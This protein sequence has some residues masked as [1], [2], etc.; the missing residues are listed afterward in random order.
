MK[1]AIMQPYFFPYAGYF[2]LIDQVDKFVFYDDVGF[3]K[4][5]W[6]NRNRLLMAGEAR[7]FTVPLCGASPNL[8]INQVK[9]QP[10]EMWERKLLASIQQSY[11]KAPN[12]AMAFDCLREVLGAGEYEGIA[13]LAKRSIRL[14]AERIGLSASFVESSAVYGNQ[15]LCS[16]ARVIDICQKECAD[17]Y[18][19]PL[20]GRGLYD[21]DDFLDVGI[22]LKFNDA[23]LRFYKQFSGEF[24][25]GLSVLDMMMFNTFEECKFLIC[26][27]V[28]EG[29]V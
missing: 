24:V 20:G 4:G 19:N 15:H 25:P 27:D 2:S 6:I 17:V 16:S 12:F 18:I 7:Y 5:G 28:N 9:V 26:S 29:G 3:I 1:L 23:P 22:L 11:S 10:R 8:K 14:T 13:Q 21:N